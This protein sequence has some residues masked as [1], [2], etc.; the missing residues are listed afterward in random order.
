MIASKQLSTGVGLR[1]STA[2]V[3]SH[4]L[5]FS[6]AEA[7]ATG[8][9]SQFKKAGLFFLPLEASKEMELPAH[10]NSSAETQ[11]SFSHLHIGTK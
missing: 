5:V 3:E 10:G 6:G 1:F 11:L 4:L 2:N 8:L 9:G 7:G